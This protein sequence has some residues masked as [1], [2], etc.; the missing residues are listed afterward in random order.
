VEKTAAKPPWKMLRVSTFPQPR[1][2]RTSTYECY[3]RNP[4][5]GESLI[6]PELKTGGRSEITPLVINAAEVASNAFR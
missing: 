1:R 5:P 6:I 4:N 3:A 2:L